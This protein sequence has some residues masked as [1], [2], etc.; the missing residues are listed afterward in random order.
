MT[1]RKPS[2]PQACILR[3]IKPGGI[4]SMTKAGGAYDVYQVEHLRLPDQRSLFELNVQRHYIRVHRNIFC[5]MPVAHL[6]HIE[7]LYT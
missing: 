4:S 1:G 2:G 6:Y 7:T 5:V 3:K